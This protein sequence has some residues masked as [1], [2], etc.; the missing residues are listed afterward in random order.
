MTKMWESMCTHHDRQLRIVTGLKS[1][2]TSGFVLIETSK[3]HHERTKQLSSVVEQWHSQ[4]EKLVANQRNYVNALNG[5]LKLNLIPIESTL[6]EKTAS[7]PPQAATPPI[8]PLLRSWHDHLEKLPDEV[9]KSSIASFA[10][11]IK[12]II[13]HQEEEMKLKEKYEETQKEYLRKKMGFEEWYQKYMQKRTP[14]DEN[15]PE[16]GKDPVSERQLVVESL[17]KR[18]EEEMEEHQ[19]ICVQVR[20]KSLGNLKIRLPEL[21]R[22]LSDYARACLDAYGRLRA[23]TQDPN[24]GS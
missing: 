9:A 17:K 22:A 6:R 20:E 3:H 13:I 18:L 10:A 11:V 16:N 1:L 24:R 19:K 14:N 12:T 15:D 5:W 2:D 4:F 21:F 7:S 8:Q 23:L